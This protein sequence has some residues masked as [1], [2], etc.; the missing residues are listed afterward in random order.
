LAG[1]AGYTRALGLLQDLCSNSGQLPSC[2]EL[3]NV[4]FD[5][6]NMVGRGGEVSVYGGDLNGRKVVVREVQMPR[7]FWS[8]PAGQEVIKVIQTFIKL[9]NSHLHYNIS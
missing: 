6:R 2:L 1:P 3:P 7:W 4:T 8:S 9:V 5:R